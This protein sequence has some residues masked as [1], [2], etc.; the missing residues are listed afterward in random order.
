MASPELPTDFA[1]SD[2]A[3]G[4]HAYRPRTLY[5]EVADVRA[6][7]AAAQ[8]AGARLVLGIIEQPDA[9]YALLLDANGCPF[10]LRGR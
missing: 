3:L 4:P 10:G 1:P 9:A 2:S 8:R 6:A 5:R 7:T